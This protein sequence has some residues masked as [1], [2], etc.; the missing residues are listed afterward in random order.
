[1]PIVLKIEIIFS[2]LLYKGK[3]NPMTFSLKIK[4]QYGSKSKDFINTNRLFS[5][6][7][8]K[9]EMVHMF[10]AIDR[11]PT[12][13]IVQVNIT[14]SNFEENRAVTMDLPNYENDMKQSKLTDSMQKLR[15]KFGIDIIKNDGEL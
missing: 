2:I 6:S 9:Q 1:V 14:L 3:H 10:A 8:F 4:Y 12:H 13:A 11:H 15:D 5:E 7:H